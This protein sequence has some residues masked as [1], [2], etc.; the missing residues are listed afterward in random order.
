M[1]LLTAV[2][3][4]LVVG[5][6]LAAAL[7]AIATSAADAGHGDAE[8]L[9]RPDLPEQWQRT[10]GG[11]GDDTFADLVRTDD[12][13]YLAVGWASGE[14]RDG[15]VVKTDA[16]GEIEWERTYGESGT[17]RFYGVARAEDGYV[18][19]GRT[20]R[21][22][23]P[24]GWIVEVGPDGEVVAERTPSAGAFYALEADDSGYL[25]AGWT[26]SDRREGVALRLDENRS[27]EWTEAYPTPERYGDGYLRAIVPRESGY[28]LAGKVEGE[29]DDGW[30][31]AIGADGAEQWQ[32]TAGGASRDDVWAA[33]PADGGFVFA[34]ETESNATGP[35]DGW[36]VKVGANGS[37]AWERRPGGNGTQWLD[38]AM[39]TEEGFLFTGSSN[40]GPD[41]S[42]DGYVVAT[43]A[44][45]RV[46]DESYYGTSGWDKPWPA[47]RGHDGGYLLAGQTGGADA[48]GRDG[49]LVRIGSPNATDAETTERATTDTPGG[50]DPS[51]TALRAE[52]ATATETPSTG[53][54]GFGPVVA[55][56]GVVL[57][58]LIARR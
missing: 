58:V 44:D 35:R 39:R 40:A 13:G 49:W 5:A 53:V 28:Y 3:T 29:T 36:L 21:E 33:A 55:V 51:T 16:E 45:G 12:G 6:G 57:A 7:P 37:V 34:G 56:V 11:E 20:D 9:A 19:A 31:L 43:D 22:G 42:A 54:P 14:D 10:H 23:S 15:W 32:T 50:D 25:L 52:T 4:A 2:L 27:T 30:A 38:S 18:L 46:T 47:I 1:R 26:R 17:D 24:R 48:D 8:T 41:G